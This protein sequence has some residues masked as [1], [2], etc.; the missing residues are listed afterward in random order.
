MKK[1][2]KELA[3]LFPLDHL[4]V[5]AVAYVCPMSDIADFCDNIYL[6]YAI[7]LVAKKLDIFQTSPEDTEVRFTSTCTVVYIIHMYCYPAQLENVVCRPL[8]VL[9]QRV[10]ELESIE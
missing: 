7:A 5:F 1:H 2:Y 6:P 10:A 8:A 4:L 3:L 9:Q